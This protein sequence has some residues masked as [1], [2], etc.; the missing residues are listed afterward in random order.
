MRVTHRCLGIAPNFLGLRRWS[1]EIAE[2]R[3]AAIR[4]R[5]HHTLAKRCEGD[6]VIAATHEALRAARL[7]VKVAIRKAKAK[8]WEELI[9]SLDGSVVTRLSCT[10]YSHGCPQLRNVWTPS[11]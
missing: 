1:D 8:A 3:Q 5:C 9:S 6:E 11:F 4:A 7:A 2:F 10:S